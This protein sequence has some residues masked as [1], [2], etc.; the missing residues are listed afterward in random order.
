MEDDDDTRQ[1]LFVL[2]VTS[3]LCYEV[4]FAIG[5][6]AG[7]VLDKVAPRLAAESR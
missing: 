7:V 4:G 3:V 2:V 5:V 1:R 6:V